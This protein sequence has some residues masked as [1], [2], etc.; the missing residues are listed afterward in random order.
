MDSSLA[1]AFGVSLEVRLKSHQLCHAASCN[2]VAWIR[3]QELWVLMWVLL[4]ACMNLACMS[5]LSLW[6]C[7]SICPMKDTA[8]KRNELDSYATSGQLVVAGYLG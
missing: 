1:S 7:F 3:G 8:S 2:F 5:Q 4:L 6:A